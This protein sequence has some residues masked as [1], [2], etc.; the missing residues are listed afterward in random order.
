MIDG[1]R[2]GHSVGS[3]VWNDVSL[4]TSAYL[5]ASLSKSI[6]INE[7]LDFVYYVCLD[8]FALD[9]TR[10]M[11]FRRHGALSSGHQF[12]LDPKSIAIIGVEI[13]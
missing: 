7:F 10:S 5:Y 12:G 1:N 3:R 11:P 4:T 9:R 13:F 8:I 6:N 2:F